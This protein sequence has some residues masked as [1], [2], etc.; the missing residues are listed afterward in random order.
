[1]DYR[2][3]LSEV[4]KDKGVTIKQLHESTGVSTNTIHLIRSNRSKG[5]QLATLWKFCTFLECGIE[6]LIVKED[7]NEYLKARILD[8]EKITN[9]TFYKKENG[10]ILSDEYSASLI[11]NWV[12]DV[13][14][15]MGN[16]KGDY[17]LLYEGDWIGYR[18][19]VKQ[20]K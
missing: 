14:E 3:K 7:E 20:D 1:M 12:G 17:E 11:I 2:F 8:R 6:D 16:G 15:L 10:E 5:I 13:Y 9:I 18:I 4:M 19:E